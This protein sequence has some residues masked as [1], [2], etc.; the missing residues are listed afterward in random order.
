MFS[1][2]EQDTDRHNFTGWLTSVNTSKTWSFPAT[3]SGTLTSA[4]CRGPCGWDNAPEL[5]LKWNLWFWHQP[6]CTNC[7]H[8]GCEGYKCR[9][10]PQHLFSPRTRWMVSGMSDRIYLCLK[11]FVFFYPSTYV[12]VL[13]FAVPLWCACHSSVVCIG[14]SVCFSPQMTTSV[15]SS[16]ECLKRSVR[17]KASRFLFFLTHWFL[18]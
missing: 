12:A 5:A 8:S 9:P 17:I 3:G 6:L 2:K 11:E 14:E 15:I 16:P 13:V 1:I 4:A 7:T 10:V 18:L